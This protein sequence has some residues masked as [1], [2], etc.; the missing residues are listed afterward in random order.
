MFVAY[1]SRC[2]CE[3]DGND[4]EDVI[5]VVGVALVGR[6]RARVHTFYTLRASRLVRH[7]I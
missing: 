6:A 2:A 4:D 1:S 7:I 5:V 3:R